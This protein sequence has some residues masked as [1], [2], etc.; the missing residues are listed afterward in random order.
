M[1]YTIHRIVSDDSDHK[2]LPVIKDTTAMPMVDEGR[3]S[4]GAYDHAIDAASTIPCAELSDSELVMLVL[5]RLNKGE[6]SNIRDYP[7]FSLWVLLDEELTSRGQEKLESTTVKGE[8]VDYHSVWGDDDEIV[9]DKE[10]AYAEED[11]DEFALFD[12]QD[13]EG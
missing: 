11:E 13:W 12:S 6:N 9:V 2:A 1:N 4:M 3:S 5:A 7:L 8:T 10:Y